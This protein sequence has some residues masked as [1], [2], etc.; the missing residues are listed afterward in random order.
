M[1]PLLIIIWPWR[2]MS[3]DVQKMGLSEYEKIFDIE[4]HDMGKFINKKFYET[5]KKEILDL[6]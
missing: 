6:D 1:K 5:F 2:F 4:I 3:Y